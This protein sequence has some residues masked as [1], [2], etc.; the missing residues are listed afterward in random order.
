MAWARVGFYVSLAIT[1]FFP[2]LQLAVQ[3]GLS[4]TVYFYAPITQSILVYL[5]GALLYA[6]KLPERWRPGWFDYA[7]G[8]HNIW[9]LA[10]L[11]GILYHYVAMQSF[12][13]EAFRRAKMECSTY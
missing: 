12:F 10:V 2:V 5:T 3:R 9:H 4:E 8:S 11:G 7:G 6:A 13:S 1:G